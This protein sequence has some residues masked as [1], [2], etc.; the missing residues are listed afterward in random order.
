M[1]GAKTEPSDGVESG[2]LAQLYLRHG[3]EAVRLGYLL[4]GDRA[5]AEDL[6]QE[7]FVRIAGRL[8]HLRDPEAFA[9]YLR[10]TVVNL[11]RMH[12]RRRRLERAH[13]EKERPPPH[14]GEPEADVATQEALRAGLLRLPHRQ[15]AAI[16][17]RYYADLP[18]TETADVL[19]CS[20]ATVRSLIS[21]GM[22]RL[23]AEFRGE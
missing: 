14:F 17:L 19:G 15:R 22:E 4:T 2:R 3:H 18:D 8:G 10:R 7:A 20:R 9:A 23:R 12:F 13:A 21:R 16:V 11:S 5:V 6:A 1:I